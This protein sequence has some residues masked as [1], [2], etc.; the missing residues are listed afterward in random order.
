MT[1]YTLHDRPLNVGDKVWLLKISD[2]IEAIK[3]EY[4]AA[5][6]NNYAWDEPPAV[7]LSIIP[8]PL[9]WIEGHPV[10]KGTAMMHKEGMALVVERTDSFV[11]E[12]VTCYSIAG[13]MVTVSFA[14]L[15]FSLPP[16]SR[17]MKQET[18]TRWFNK[19]DKYEDG[20]LYPTEREA[21]NGA[22]NGCQGQGSFSYEV[23]VPA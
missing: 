3:P 20:G 11:E 7:D 8:P 5:Y 19:Y 12:Y 1:T 13:H 4:I 21:K 16:N 23:E 15:T 17:L 9:C 22:L 14:N 18:R 2:F 10:R 6:P